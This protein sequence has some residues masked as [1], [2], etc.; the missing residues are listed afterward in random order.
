MRASIVA[1]GLGTR[2]VEMTGGRIPKALLPV[3]GVPIIF[4]QLRVLQRE[5]I[6]D[7]SVLAGHL[8]PQLQLALEPEAARLGLRLQMIV[9]L[10]PLGTGGCLSAL[11]SV[12]EDVLVVYGDMLF[13]ISLA[14]LQEFHR[15]HCPLLTIVAHP[16]DHPRTSDLLLEDQDILTAVMP[17]DRP[18]NRDF[19]NLVPTGVYLATPAFLTS[20]R[21]GVKADMIRDVL[22][23][24]LRA[25]AKIAVYNTPEYLRD[26][27]TPARH[28]LAEQDVCAGRPEKLN[29]QRL[30]PAIFFDCDG[31]LNEEPGSRGAVSPDDVKTISGAGAAVARAREAGRL[32]IAITNRPQVAKGFISFEGLSEILG[33]LEA[34]LAADGGVL[35]RIYYCPHHPMRGFAGEQLSLKVRCECRKPGTLLLRRAVADLPI[36]KF[37]SVMIGD[38]LRDVGAAH[39][40]GIWA[41]GVRTG[42]GCN[43]ADRYRAENG[44]IASRC[45]LMFKDV[46]EA[47]SF[48]LSYEFMASNAVTNVSGLISLKPAPIVVAVCGQSRAGKSS[49]AH[50]LQRVLT[51]QQVACRLIRLDDWILPA[52]KRN[53]CNAELRNRVDK[54]PGV[55]QAL[56]KGELITAPGYDPQ[57]RGESDPIR[58]DSSGQTVLIVEGCFAGH[59]SIRAMVDFLIFVTTPEEIRRDRF[60]DF[61]RWKGLGETA[62]DSLWRDRINDE[63]SLINAQHETA[64]MVITLGDSTQ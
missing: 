8:A 51:H 32:A 58:Y 44:T 64:D 56:R 23:S 42:L 40:F 27:G 35:D 9:E 25:G 55:L 3:S 33:R 26:V 11:G 46:V 31:V 15:R 49:F 39:G 57:S 53:G 52:A 47:V 61:Y 41:Y 28:S 34:E 48:E 4:R 5:G 45:D 50:A 18:P 29:R 36:D 10:E 7:V 38:S 30:R 6:S 62:I 13:D 43:D 14:P 37:R 63:W 21:K 20:L 59:S 12:N 17:R 1:G 19:R 60:N 2:A 54:L 24:L 16:N 22:P